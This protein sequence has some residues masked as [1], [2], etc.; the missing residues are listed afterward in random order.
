MRR[1]TILKIILWLCI[2]VPYMLNANSKLDSLQNQLEYITED[3][4][5]IKLYREIG[6]ILLSKKPIEA[7]KYYEAGRILAESIKDSS[8]LRNCLLG[9]CDVN[10]MMHDHKAALDI[11][12]Q[13]IKTANNNY[14]KLPL[15]YNRLSI[16]YYQLGD[17]KKSFKS[18][19]MSLTYNLLNKDTLGIAYDMH[20][21]GTYYM[22]TQQYDS[23]LWYYQKSNQYIA[24]YDDSLPLYNIS[25]M[26][27]LFS[28]QGEPER[29]I[30]LHTE[31]MTKF[32]NL[33]LEVEALNEEFYIADTYRSLKKLKEAQRYA[34]QVVSK[35]NER[36]LYS[37]TKRGYKVLMEISEKQNDYENAFKYS[38]LINTYSDSIYSRENEELILSNTTRF[39]YNQ[40]KKDLEHSQTK[41]NLLQKQKKLLQLITLLSALLSFALIYFIIGLIINSN[42]NKK[43]LQ[44]LNTANST[45][46]KLISIIGHDLIGSVGNLKNFVKMLDN[47][48]LSQENVNKLMPNI[49]NGVNSTFDLIENLTAWAKSNQENFTPTFEIIDTQ[50]LIEQA[51]NQVSISSKNKRITIHSEARIKQMCGDHN[52]ILMVIRNL[53]TN[54]VK[55]SEEKSNIYITIEKQGSDIQ[56]SVRDEGTGINAKNI[57][58]ILDPDVSYHTKGT[59]NETGSGL[60]ITLS[61]T[62]IKEHGGELRIES[63]PGKGSTFLF[64]IPQ[65]I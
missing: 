59:K 49:I 17:L 15:I 54:A 37:L 1:H 42:K 55:F 11:V 6:E 61:R 36:R 8:E 53:L 34:Q 45:K 32:K 20:N 7:L 10:T 28:R 62:F 9:I 23:A 35:A 5:K 50:K 65:E 14:E 38:R 56:I 22:D 48:S 29:A 63:E 13:L 19:S 33:N 58:E 51:K 46:S 18:D 47:K 3:T 25:R 39:E 44:E 43:L 41:N 30:S 64:S 57:E 52:M 2:T 21:I 60:G 4:S 31:A 12:Q 24:D 40:Q 26:G 16:I 27:L